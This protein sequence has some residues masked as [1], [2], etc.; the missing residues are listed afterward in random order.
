MK[1]PLRDSRHSTSRM[2]RDPRRR[3]IAA[4]DVEAHRVAD[5][6]IAA[7]SAIS[8]STDTSASADG[9]SQN[10]PWIDPLVRLEVIAIGDREL[11][12]ERRP[13]ARTSSTLSSVRL[14]AGDADHAR[15]QHRNQLELAGAVRRIAE[16]R[17]HAV[18]LRPLD[19]EQEHVRRVL[20]PPAPRTRS[21]RLACSDRTP[22]MKKAPRPT[23]SRMTRVWLPGRDRC[24]TAWRSGNDREFASGAISA[25]SAR[26][27]RCSTTASAA[28][29]TQTTSPTL[30]RRRLP[31]GQRDQRQPTRRRSPRCP[32]QSRARRTR[33]VAQQQR[34]L[35]EPHLQQRHDR[36]QQRHQHADRRCPAA[37]AL[38]LTP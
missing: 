17:A 13:A 29:P 20:P 18:D 25:T 31:G 28:K 34:R 23:A 38:Q 4:E 16:K 11:A 12:A 35:D 3:S 24:S 27:A 32:V 2:L 6:Q 30:Q 21:S 33:L 10:A 22:T 26:P 37:A 36:E 1:P 15:A 19:V 8:F 5:V 14:A 9:P 7:R